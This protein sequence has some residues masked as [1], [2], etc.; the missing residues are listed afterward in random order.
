[1]SAK[2]IGT[3]THYYDKIG[4]AVIDL[5]GLLKVGDTVHIFGRNTDFHQEV[6][7]MQIEH[8]PIQEAGPGQEVAMKVVQRVR[9]RD[10]VYVIPTVE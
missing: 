6:Q 10:K 8:M 3:I 1:M 9:S 5:Q 7:S 2:L 4:V